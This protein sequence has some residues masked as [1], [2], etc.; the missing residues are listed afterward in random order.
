MTTIW[1]WHRPGKISPSG[2][3]VTCRNCGALI[4]WCSC[5]SETFRHCDKNRAGCGGSMWVAVVRGRLANFINYL[6]ACV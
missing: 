4:E 5:V 6:E 3:S 2:K 1:C